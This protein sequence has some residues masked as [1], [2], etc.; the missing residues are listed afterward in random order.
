LRLD[1]QDPR[2]TPHE[3]FR[4]LRDGKI[5]LLQAQVADGWGDVYPFTL[6]ERH[7]IDYEVANWFT[8]TH[9]SSRF[10][11][12]LV[13]SRAG[14]ERKRSALFDRELIVRKGALAEK[15]IIETPD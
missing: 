7:P 2:P 14:P 4:V 9:P 1:I 10:V 5:Y 6:E 15:Q 8:S 12:N 3:T 13:V 11:Q